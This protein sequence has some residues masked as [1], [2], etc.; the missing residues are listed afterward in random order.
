MPLI[1]SR[2]SPAGSLSPTTAVSLHILYAVAQSNWEK[3]AKVSLGPELTT[4]LRDALKLALQNGAVVPH[5]DRKMGGD[6]MLFGRAG[7]LWLLLNV[8][9]YKFSADTETALAPVL[10]MIPQLIRVIIEAGREGSKDY[11]QSHGEED[12]HPLMYPWMEGHYALGA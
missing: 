4:Y 9:A 3:D 6:E 5:N 10:D 8:R 1:P 12:A 7:L 11:V 2:L